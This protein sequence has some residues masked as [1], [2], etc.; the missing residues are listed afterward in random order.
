MDKLIYRKGIFVDPK[1]NMN[2]LNTSQNTE[3]QNVKRF[4]E[5]D[6][7]SVVSQ[8]A[9]IKRNTL[10]IESENNDQASKIDSHSEGMSVL[11]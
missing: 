5:K 2:E 1:N 9:N 3:Q 11:L 4:R 7:K 6:F 8:Y 10:K